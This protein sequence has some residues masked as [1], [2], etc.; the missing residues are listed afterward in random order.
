M[1]D[2]FFVGSSHKDMR[3]VP[4][5][6]R[7]RAGFELYL[8]QQGLEPSDWKPMSTIGAG[9]RELRIHDGGEY[10]VMY[11]TTIGDA[12]YVL[13]A[14]QKKSQK[15]PQADIDLAKQRYETLH[16]GQKS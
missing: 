15:T 16:R 5:S 7:R 6:A 4:A 14:F 3:R 12:V 10:R 8:V 9:V 13:H 2:L 1:K 11:V